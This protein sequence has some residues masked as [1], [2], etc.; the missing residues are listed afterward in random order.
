MGSKKL[1]GSERDDEISA[2]SSKKHNGEPLA[3]NHNGKDIQGSLLGVIVDEKLTWNGH[4]VAT[5]NKL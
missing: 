1:T 3:N 5:M 4:V 2:L